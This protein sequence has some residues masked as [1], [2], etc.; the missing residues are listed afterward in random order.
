MAGSARRQPRCIRPAAPPRWAP[1]LAA[2]AAGLIA[3]GAPAAAGAQTGYHPPHR[4]FLAQGG[5][6]VIYGDYVRIGDRVAFLL[7]LDA[8]A[9]RRAVQL[10]TVPVGA[11]DWETTGRYADAVRAARYA[12]SRGEADFE[13]MTAEVAHT[14]NE[15]AFTVDPRERVALARSTRQR[16]LDWTDANHGYRAREVVEIVALLDEAVSVDTG[17]GAQ[18]ELSVSLVATTGR[19][20]PMPVLPNPTLQEIIARALTVSRLTSV[21]EE[22]T[23]VL[24]AVVAALDDPRG[25]LGAEWREVTRAIAARDLDTEAR[26]AAAYAELRRTALAQAADYARQADVRGVR[27]V[28]DTVRVRDGELGR[29]NPDHLQALLAAIEAYLAEARALRLERDHRLYAT[30]AV[31]T[32]GAGVKDVMARFTASRAGL[33]DIRLLAG[34]AAPALAALDLRLTDALASLGDHMPPVEARAVHEL[35]RQ[36]FNLAATAARQRYEAVLQGDLRGAWDSAA[37]AAGALMLFDR[38]AVELD[39][40]LPQTERN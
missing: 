16:L 10:V 32:Y 28:L 4:L 1:L 17:D 8:E 12:A 40:V 22:R 18:G 29:R 14:L 20:H 27:T 19:P 35:L 7:P 24:Q 37:A 39:R 5:D 21:P 38:A 33:D 11:L 23:A 25:T 36:A 2:L 31:R 6:L 30:A 26:Q 3:A 13:Q 34:P 9:G 15:I